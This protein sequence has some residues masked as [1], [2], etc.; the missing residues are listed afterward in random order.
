LSSAWSS[1][2]LAAFWWRTEFPFRW[3]KVISGG[4]SLVGSLF[5]GEE[6][7]PDGEEEDDLDRLVENRTCNVWVL[8]VFVF[9][10]VPL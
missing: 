7:P 6:P 2:A 3:S 9:V 10:R 4:W 5:L 1:A 8:F